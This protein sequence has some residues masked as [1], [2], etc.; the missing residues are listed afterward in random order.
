MSDL[1]RN[2]ALRDLLAVMAALRGDGGCPWDRGQTHRSLL[3]YLIE[4]A[5]EFI[6]AV[7]RESEAGMREELGDVLFQVVFHA[8]IARERG[9][10]GFAEVARDLAQKLRQRHPHVFGD[11]PLESAEA[12]NAAWNARKRA[13]YRSHLE[14][15]P[16]GLPALQWAAKVASRAADAGFEW[17]REAEILD[18]AREELEEFAAEAGR[19][20][21]ERAALET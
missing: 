2:D 6:E 1:T 5:Y 18:K 7:E 15:V 3:P 8:E 20:Q 10:F 19:S 14:G 4:E 13:G 16:A 9:A 12:V 21:T 17:N 11:S